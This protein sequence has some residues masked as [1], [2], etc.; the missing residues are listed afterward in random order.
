MPDGTIRLVERV[1]VADAPIPSGE[2]ATAGVTLHLL[3]GPTCPVVRDPPDPACDAR[4]IVNGEVVIRSPDG[5]ELARATSN[6]AGEIALQLP[7]AAYYVEPQPVEGLLGTAAAIA[8]S[9]VGGETV[10]LNLD[11]DTGIR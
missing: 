11:Y 8:F 1:G 7:P 4:P 6:E 2:G 9:V 5:T 3:A 10:D